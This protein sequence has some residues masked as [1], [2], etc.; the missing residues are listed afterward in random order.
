M[1]RSKNR[2]FRETKTR[3]R[4]RKEKRERRVEGAFYRELKKAKE[5]EG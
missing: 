4:A 5:K 1:E 3:V 2:K